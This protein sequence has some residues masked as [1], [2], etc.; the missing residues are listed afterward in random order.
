MET[1]IEPINNGNYFFYL[2]NRR[3]N[4]E[5][6]VQFGSRQ[7]TNNIHLKYLSVVLGT[8]ITFKKRLVK[9]PV[10]IKIHQ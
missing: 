5:K 4:H 7:V 1:Q 10:K 8:A 6:H 9:L 2:D 3:A